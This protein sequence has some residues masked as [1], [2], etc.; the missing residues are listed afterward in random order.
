MKCPY[1]TKSQTDILQWKQEFEDETNQ[2]INGQQ[3]TRTEFE[4]M[5]CLKE[6]CMAYCDGKC[7]YKT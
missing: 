5:D 1:N 6:Q 2:P 3:V 4:L 7:N